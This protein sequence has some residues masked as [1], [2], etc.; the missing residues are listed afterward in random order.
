MA[1]PE[2]L[3][4]WYMEE[5]YKRYMADV[6]EKNER[7]RQ[8][9]PSYPKVD[10]NQPA[11]SPEAERIRQLEAMGERDVYTRLEEDY[12]RSLKQAPPQAAPIVVEKTPLSLAERYQAYRPDW[13]KVTEGPPMSPGDPGWEAWNLRKAGQFVSA[14]YQELSAPL[15]TARDYV[16]GAITGSP[17]EA[18]TPHEVGSMVGEPSVDWYK[19]IIPAIVETTADLA[20]DPLA[21]YTLNPFRK[22]I[23]AVPPP[24][25]GPTIPPIQI[26]DIE[27]ARRSIPSATGAPDIPP[28]GPQAIP[29]GKTLTVPA[30][31]PGEMT[32][33]TKYPIKSGRPTLVP[34]EFEDVPPIPEGQTSLLAVPQEGGKRIV[35]PGEQLSQGEVPLREQVFRHPGFPEATTAKAVEPVTQALE[36]LAKREEGKRLLRESQSPL[37]D[38]RLKLQV[39]PRGSVSVTE[40][41]KDAGLRYTKDPLVPTDIP[42]VFP[43][44][45]SRVTQSITDV[46]SQMGPPGKNIAGA[47][48]NILSNRSVFTSNDVLN[49][50]PKL[51]EIAGRRP[52]ASRVIE[53]FR[54]LSQGE[55]AFVWG[56]HRYFNL[57]EQEVE[58]VW[59]YLYTNGRMIPTSTKARAFGDQLYEGMLYGPSASAHEAGLSLY[60]PLTGKHEAFGAPGKFM[61]QIPVHP[62]SIQ[63]I[64]DTHLQLLY[65]RQ[66]GFDGTGKTFPMWK[67]QL[68]RIM[69]QGGELREAKAAGSGMDEAASAYDLASKKY[70]G[71]EVTRLL[72]LEALGGSPYQWAKKLGYETDPFR[73][74][75]RYNSS[76]Y[77]RSEWARAMPQLEKDV[78]QIA[79]KGGTDI[80]EWV[81][82]AINRS[83]GINTG[84]DETRFLRQLVKGVR[85]FNNVTMLQLGGIGSSPQLGY[86][87]ARAPLSRSLL[88][89]V[90]FVTGNNRELVEK[91]GA[92]FPTL[93]NTMIQPEG[94][95][96]T[97]STGA[98][99]TYG[100][101]LLDKWSRYFGGH[102][103]VRYV[104]F[105]EK[106]LL[107]YPNKQRLH[108]L[109]DEMGGDVNTI[110]R[111]GRIPEP[112]KYAMIQRYANYAAGIPDA[113]G[114]PLH[115]TNETSYARLANQYRLFLYNNQAEL[116]RLWKEAPTLTDAIARISKVIAGTG[117]IAAGSGA[118]SEA[119][120][121][122][123]TE[124][125]GSPFVNKK[126]KELVGDEGSA[127]ALQTLLYGLGAIYAA[128]ILTALDGGWKLAAQLTGGP[129]ASLAVGVKDDVIDSIIEGPGW[130][131][132][133]TAARR[134][135]IA[136]PVLAPIVQ[137]EAKEEARRARKR[138]DLR[139]SLK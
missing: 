90:D 15:A 86:A 22:T 107:K 10:P 99:R 26:V 85:D 103:G 19:N 21:L 124:G 16:L 9:N 4:K 84:L 66:G 48:Q 78:A 35:G 109:I 40:A 125:S 126:L 67:A 46:L 119:I 31:E 120:R 89:A 105:L 24:Q 7:R 23:G 100:V 68:K 28:P 76:A 5:E 41:E 45:T 72:D 6:L 87:L 37:Q 104:D 53:G 12:Q 39:S 139:R 43:G 64:S 27:V 88:G 83:Q 30:L 51:T 55:N 58:Q 36:K 102:V 135:P 114:L 101:S 137:E 42:L 38:Y 111:E 80:T 32:S 71:L 113:R 3:E 129:T 116:V 106:A 136:G 112:M 81:V 56:T 57:S 96:S 115:A 82:K 69:S 110:I 132:A 47:I 17:G 1:T 130:K 118:L 20:G 25:G 52:P 122:S 79:E 29:T 117:T 128:T 91:S 2:E 11:F 65:N 131:S 94:P 8:E 34:G 127:F 133:R 49:T 95:L 97:I 138:E 121:N 59:N 54:E 14:P 73:A 134:T 61:P 108:T 93:L 50:T 70:K 74:A 33:S 44:M 92:A 75:F 123:F 62:V 77:L 63:N 18:R 13:S 60:N 98:L